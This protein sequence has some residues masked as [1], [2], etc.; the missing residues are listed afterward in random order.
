MQTWDW[1]LGWEDSLGKG[2]VT[3]SVFLLEEF[4]RQRSLVGNP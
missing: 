4:Y 3:H 1:F 2:I